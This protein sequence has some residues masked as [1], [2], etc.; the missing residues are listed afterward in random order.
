MI[1]EKIGQLLKSPLFLIC[2]AVLSALF[3]YVTVTKSPQLQTTTVGAKCSSG[4]SFTC[5]DGTT[6]C[7]QNCPSGEVWD[8]TSKKCVCSGTNKKCVKNTEC[9]NPCENDVCCSASNQITVNGVVSCCQP[10]TMPGKLSASS[11]VNDTCLVSCGTKTCGSGEAC[12]KVTNLVPSTYSKMVTQS[13]VNG[14]YQDPTNAYNNWITFCSDPSTCTFSNESALPN[15][16]GNNYTY[17]NFDTFS[18][19]GNK[20]GVCINSTPS[21]T[22][23]GCYTLQDQAGCGADAS[24]K[25]ATLPDDYDSNGPVGTEL[26]NYMNY[27][28]GGIS[29][30]YYCDPGNLPLGSIIQYPGQ[31]SGCSWQSCVNQALNQGTVDLDWNDSNKTCTAFRVPPYQNTGFQPQQQIQCT[32]VQKPCASCTSKND[33]VNAIKCTDVGKPCKNCKA[34]GD[35]ICIDSNVKCDPIS[36][37]NNW[38]FDTCV[39]NDANSNAVRVLGPGAGNCPWGCTTPSKSQLGPGGKPCYSTDTPTGSGN[40]FGDISIYAG[41]SGNVCLQN[42]QIIPEPTSPPISYAY[43]P[44]NYVC[45]EVSSATTGSYAN[46]CECVNAIYNGDVSVPYNDQFL[47]YQKLSDGTRAYMYYN[48]ADRY[49]K[50]V[51]NNYDDPNIKSYGN[52]NFVGDSTGSLVMSGWPFGIAYYILN[53]DFQFL[54]ATDGDY[55]GPNTNA[56][57][58]TNSYSHALLVNIESIKKLNYN[59]PYF[60]TFSNTY[61][62][63]LTY[64]NEGLAIY[65]TPATDNAVYFTRASIEDQKKNSGC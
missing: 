20:F 53:S 50:Y 31:G 35:Y 28:N 6:Q 46:I 40:T 34:T 26:Q 58:T 47:I 13:N 8:C 17:Y 51:L 23:T 18:S 45:S 11:T 2:L 15:S 41:S 33:F 19:P 42:G 54:S 56:I 63:I 10:G 22:S 4:N 29:G 14:S 59:S 3:I 7:V 37:N 12:M 49:Y 64:S 55:H 30:G 61:H 52:I 39:P 1:L 60:C 32:D 65:G 38:V 36:D 48:P 25:W 43:D 44:V 9:C 16:I 21:T 57:G 27:K 62:P 24:C 5:P